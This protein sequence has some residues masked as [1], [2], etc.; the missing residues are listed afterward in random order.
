MKKIYLKTIDGKERNFMGDVIMHEHAVEFVRAD[1]S[2]ATIL[3]HYI[4]KIEVDD[5]HETNIEQLGNVQ[6]PQHVHA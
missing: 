5:E 2:G 4:D 6:T 1:G 3:K